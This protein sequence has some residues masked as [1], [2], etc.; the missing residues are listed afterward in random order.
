MLN[1]MD[2]IC[3]V[4]GR[5]YLLQSELHR[6]LNETSEYYRSA[7]KYLGCTP[8]ETLSEKDKR[9]HA[10]ALTTAAI[11]GE[12]VYNFGELVSDIE[13]IETLFLLV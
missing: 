10:V 4:H 12:E 8:M 5:F 2:G 11:T 3:T 13:I 9:Y 6:Q 1:A 7:L